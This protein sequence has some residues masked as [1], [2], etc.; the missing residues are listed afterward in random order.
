M[1][2]HSSA[3]SGGLSWS[4]LPRNQGYELRAN[5]EIVGSLHRPSFWS[6]NFVAE[7]QSGQ[8]TF[9]RGGFLGSGAQIVDLASQQQIA[10]FKSAWDGGGTL[11]FADGQTFHLECK[12]FWHPVWRVIAESGETLLHLHT[13]ERT[14]EVATGAAVRD[15][16]LSLLI[17]FTW[18][19]VLQAEE[20]AASAAMVAVIGA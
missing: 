7:T 6:S 13:R 20:D 10:S 16:R 15:R 14:V 11:T 4:R 5:D 12:G 19:R 17:M 1:I 9:H 2:P 8:W 3:I 18:Y